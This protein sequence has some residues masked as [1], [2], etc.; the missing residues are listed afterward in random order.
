MKRPNPPPT[1]FTLIELLVVI[2][3]IALLAGLLLPALARAKQKG[4]QTVCLSNLK[5]TGVALQMYADDNEDTLPGPAWSG[6]KACY[7]KNSSQEF[8]WFLADQ[9]SYP[10]PSTVSPAK[11]TVVDAFTCP[12]YAHTAPG[13]TTF[14]GRKCWLLNDNVN[15]D[16]DPNKRVPPFGYPAPALPPLKWSE[17]DKYA[18]RSDLFAVSDVDTANISD[19]SVSWAGDVPTRPAHGRVR[20]KLYFDSHA[21]AEPVN[22]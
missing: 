5:Q 17:L 6:A 15:T 10:N 3:I 18:A 14:V 4:Y 19:P 13:F 1:A 11:P 12:G 22:Y 9:F 21:A 7:D 2:A 16:P 20:N 8:I